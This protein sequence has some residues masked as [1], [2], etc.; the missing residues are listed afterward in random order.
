MVS[1]YNYRL[2]LSF[3]SASSAQYVIVVY[4]NLQQSYSL[5]SASL[6]NVKS[7]YSFGTALSASEV[8]ALP[9]LTLLNSIISNQLP[10]LITAGTVIDSIF[11]DF[12]YFQLQLHN[13][14]YQQII[15]I[16]L[17]D[18]MSRNVTVIKQTATPVPAPQPT[19]APEPILVKPTP[20]PTPVKCDFEGYEA[21][22]DELRQTSYIMDYISIIVTSDS[23][24]SKSTLQGIYWK[25][26]DHGSLKYVFQLADGIKE[27]NVSTDSI[28]FSLARKSTKNSKLS[29]CLTQKGSTCT[30]CAF[31]YYLS[32]GKCLPVQAECSDFNYESNTCEGCYNG[33][34]LDL[35]NV[36]RKTNYLCETSDRKGNCLTCFNNYRLSY[37]GRCVYKAAGACSDYP[38]QEDNPLCASFDKVTCLSCVKGCYLNTAGFCRIPDPNCSSFDEKNE[39][40]LVCMNDYRLSDVTKTCVPVPRQ[41]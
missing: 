38:Q 29:N 33:Y 6:V 15:L 21:I 17:F 12:P 20:A 16:V 13:T 34:Y 23:R 39:V 8:S 24:C 9:Y 19:P 10:S 7:S 41:Y 5:T 32:G 11:K 18:V 26:S 1:G 36:C 22:S 27:I 14:A 40:C 3:D 30:K 31:K 28:Q 4:Q 37:K 25:L 35:S 2:T